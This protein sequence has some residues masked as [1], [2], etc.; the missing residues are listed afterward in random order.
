MIPTPVLLVIRIYIELTDLLEDNA[1]NV[2]YNLKEN[3]HRGY[4][5]LDWGDSTKIREVMASDNDDKDE[6]ENFRE[7]NRQLKRKKQC[8][9]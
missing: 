1:S 6:V 9:N 3:L 8:Q 4:I 7:K 5:S 2:K